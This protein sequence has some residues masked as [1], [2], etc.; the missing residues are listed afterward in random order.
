MPVTELGFQDAGLCLLLRAVVRR[1][2]KRSILASLGGEADVFQQL[3]LAM[4]QSRWMWPSILNAI[5][6]ICAYASRAR[7]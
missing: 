7:T 4:P 2:G 5:T 6:S 3:A 1:E